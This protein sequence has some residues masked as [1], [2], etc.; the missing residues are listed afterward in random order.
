[1]YTLRSPMLTAEAVLLI[2]LGVAALLLPLAAGVAASL[3]FGVILILSGALGLAAS[4]ASGGRH[5][6]GWSLLSAII[7][8]VVGVLLLV[9]PLA[10]ALGL[11]LLLSVY[12]LVDGLA[13]IGMALSHRRRVTGRW[14]WLL[15]SG[16]LDVLLAVILISLNAFGSAILIGFIVGIDLIVAGIALFVFQRSAPIVTSTSTLL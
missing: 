1:M 8:L 2:V 6:R 7:A 12:L 14:S 5:P 9:H 11:T 13:L 15:G 3:V 16:L 4:F 10:G